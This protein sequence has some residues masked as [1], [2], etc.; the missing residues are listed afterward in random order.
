MLER[1][2]ESKTGFVNVKLIKGKYFQAQQHISKKGRADGGQK[3]LPGLWKT[4]LEA[5]QYRALLKR[6]GCPE[7]RPAPRKR[8]TALEGEPSL[9]H[10]LP[11]HCVSLLTTGRVPAAAQADP[12]IMSVTVRTRTSSVVDVVTPARPPLMHVPTSA[13]HVNVAAARVP[14]LPPVPVELWPGMA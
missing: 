5:A 4:A 7:H 14:M 3:P 13:V 10:A 12:N 11:R 6:E 1:S 8:M 9:P 2:T